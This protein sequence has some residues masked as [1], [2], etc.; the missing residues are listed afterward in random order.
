MCLE[1]SSEWQAA[2]FDSFWRFYNTA[3]LWP[4][5]MEGA[6]QNSTDYFY[7]NGYDQISAS[8]EDISAISDTTSMIRI[9]AEEFADEY[10]NTNNCYEPSEG[11]ELEEMMIEGHIMGDESE[12]TPEMAEFVQKTREHRQARESTHFSHPQS[13]FL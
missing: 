8:Q 1:M 7:Q 5:Q 13:R 12:W 9:G 10:L 4:S 2:D 3:Q 6:L 11:E